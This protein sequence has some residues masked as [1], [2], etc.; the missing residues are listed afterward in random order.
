MICVLAEAEI[1]IKDA[2][3]NEC[4][5]VILKKQH[6]FIS[7]TGLHFIGPQLNLIGERSFSGLI[8]NGFVPTI[9]V[10]EVLFHGFE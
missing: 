2:V 5:R 4:Q 9:L 10:T 3:E 8:K 7:K 6:M 1:N